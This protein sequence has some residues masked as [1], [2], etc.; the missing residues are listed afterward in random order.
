MNNI[1]SDQLNMLDFTEVGSVIS[2]NPA[3]RGINFRELVMQAISGEISL[4]IGGIWS[5]LSQLLF[6][7]IGEHLSVMRNL[8]VLGVLSAFLKAL[9]DSF[10]NK[11]VGE[12]GFYVNYIAIIIILFQSF[13]ISL[14]T[15][16]D[17]VFMLANLMQ[18][19]VPLMTSVIF[20]TGNIT[21][22]FVINPVLMFLASTITFFVRDFIMPAATLTASVQIINHLT[23]KEILT[24]LADLIKNTISWLLKG[25]AIIFISVLSLQRVSA[26]LLNSAISRTARSA[27]RVIP[28]VGDV[29]TGA[30]DTVMYWGS[31][32]KS[33][34]MV[35]LVIAAALVFIIPI[36][37]M[38][39]AIF[40]YKTTSALIQPICDERIVKCIDSIGSSVALLLGAMVTVIIMFLFSLMIIISL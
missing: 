39:S 34:V 31:A 25:V 35:A 22:G 12:L 14:S 3:G 32:A 37:E 13:W 38:V 15:A 26:P 8:I 29:F 40:I 23:E 2:A 18:A 7:G 21:T 20:M 11:S 9:T 16:R 33:G 17:M 36:I 10:D 19:A 4:S 6:S 28:V 27:I 1:L 5:S 24:K 30:I